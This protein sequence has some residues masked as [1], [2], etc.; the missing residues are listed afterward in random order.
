[1]MLRTMVE[2]QHPDL[3]IARQCQLLGLSRASYYY[4][5]ATESAA[6]M[7]L[8]RL[9]DGLYT[10]RPFLGS[11]KMVQE[12]WREHKVRVNRKRIQRLMRLMGIRSILPQPGTS[13]PAPQHKVYPYLL[14]ELKMQRSNQ[15]WSTDITYIPLDGGW[16]YMMAVKDWFSRFILSWELSNTMD[17]GFC[18]VGLES[19]LQRATPEIFNSDQGAQ[20]T[21]PVFTGRLEQEGVRISM[22]G[23]GRCL[24]NVW[25]ERFWRSLKY[26]EIYPRQYQDGK[27]AWE[28]INNYVE[29]FNNHRPHQA[30]GY[31]TPAEV[32]FNNL[33]AQ[34]AT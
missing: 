20:F 11:R 16:L 26:E 24:D 2:P 22:D 4:E 32:Y 7:E 15:V 27:Q 9:I 8:M 19:A 28:G 30:L 21:S 18:L 25:I 10:K 31:A 33:A 6:N 5:P 14:R 13:K 12:L 17:V 23:K 29:Y 34:V 3:S 1:M